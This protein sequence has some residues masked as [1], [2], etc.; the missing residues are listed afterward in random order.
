MPFSDPFPTIEIGEG[1]VT[2][3]TAGHE[4]FSIHNILDQDVWQLTNN[5][6]FFRGNHTFTV[7]ANFETFSFFNSFNIFRNGVF[8]LPTSAD[9]RGSSFSVTPGVLRPHRSEQPG[10]GRPDED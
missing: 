4:P 8:F 1:G 7:G 2:Y 9:G 5:F 10:P 3:T 6:S